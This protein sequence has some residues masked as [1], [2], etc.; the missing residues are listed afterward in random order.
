MTL[1]KFGK[2]GNNAKLAVTGG[3]GYTF[4]L[5]AG[6]SC[7]F[8]SACLSKADRETGKIS[9]GPHTE[10]RCFAASMESR[11][12]NV[13]ARDWHN[14]EALRAVKASTLGMVKLIEA[15]IPSDA[16]I[17][18][19]HVS[20][21]FF[22]QRYFDAWMMVADR[23]P[24]VKFYAYTKSLPF[25]IVRPEAVPRNFILTASYGGLHDGLIRLNN[26]RYAK[27][28]GTTQEAESLGLEIDHD[29]S[30]AMENG[31]SFALLI[32]GTQPKG[33]KAA[34]DKQALKGVGSYRKGG[35]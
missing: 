2:M 31:P 15:S 26:L 10:F 35:K 19:V 33:T 4:S 13:R 12:S 8:A 27:V 30:H 25:W 7:P 28:V 11:L 16:T 29:D 20:G 18:R 24:N 14:F 9:D 1:L 3:K 21:D 22:T 23:L 32:H 5:P 34:K 6:H 17:V